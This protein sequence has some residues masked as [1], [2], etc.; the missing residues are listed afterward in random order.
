MVKKL[1]MSP[2]ISKNKQCPFVIFTVIYTFICYNCILMANARLIARFNALMQRWES[3][4][5]NN[6]P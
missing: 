3:E 6:H 1:N 2:S 4:S 5:K